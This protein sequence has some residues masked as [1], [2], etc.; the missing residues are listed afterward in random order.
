MLSRVPVR[1]ARS[2]SATPTVL[3]TARVAVPGTCYD[4]PATLEAFFDRLETDRPAP[5][6]GGECQVECQC[7]VKGALGLRGNPACPRHHSPSIVGHEH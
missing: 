7:P 1:S 4:S 5:L 3:L 6:G 2:S